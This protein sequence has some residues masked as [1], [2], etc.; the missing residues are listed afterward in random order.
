LSAPLL[1]NYRKQDQIT[2][3]NVFKISKEDLTL[4]FEK[5]N[6]KLPDNDGESRISLNILRDCGYS[7]GVCRLLNTDKET[8]I[9]GDKQDILRRQNVFGKHTIAM[10]TISSFWMLLSRNFEDSSVIFLT[11]AASIYLFISLF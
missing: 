11:W 6:I 9:V 4:F 7:H 8:G 10:P 1:S 2:N 5:K 3:K